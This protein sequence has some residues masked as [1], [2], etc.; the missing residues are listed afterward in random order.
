MRVLYCTDT[1][2]PQLNGVSVVTS[3]SVEGLTRRGWECAV[4]AP[5][6]PAGAATWDEQPRAGGGPVEVF[7]VPSV[8]LPHYREVR[9]ALPRPGSVH[10]LIE[11]F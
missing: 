7:S 9:L 1:Y 6:Y 3:L 5:R 10:A 8:S 4:V 2:P 11:R